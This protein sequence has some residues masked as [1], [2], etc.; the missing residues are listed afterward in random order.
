MPMHGREHFGR[1]RVKEYSDDFKLGRSRARCS[2]FGLGTLKKSH[3]THVVDDYAH[4]FVAHAIKKPHSQTTPFR[5]S[6]HHAQKKKFMLE[7]KN[8]MLCRSIFIARSWNW[9][10]NSRGHWLVHVASSSAPRLT[11]CRE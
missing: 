9:L 5:C 4:V 1:R 8:G 10:P 6:V 11:A 7:P 3:T 2:M